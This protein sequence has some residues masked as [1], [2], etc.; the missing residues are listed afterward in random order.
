MPPTDPPITPADMA[1]IREM[2]DEFEM[3]IIQSLA[4]AFAPVIQRL[5][6]LHAGLADLTKE[7]RSA[8]SRPVGG[9]GR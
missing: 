4:D 1:A 3:R 5:D 6:Q 7:L 9:V 2:L 8:E